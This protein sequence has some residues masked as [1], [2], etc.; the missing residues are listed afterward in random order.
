MATPLFLISGLQGDS[1]A[2]GLLYRPGFALAQGSS[3]SYALM[4]SS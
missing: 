3:A 1:G 4:P 2:A